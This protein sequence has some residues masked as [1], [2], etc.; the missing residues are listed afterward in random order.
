MLRMWICC[1]FILLSPFS[2][3][4]AA[5]NQWL[6][7]GSITNQHL[8]EISGIISA[9]TFEGYWVYNDSGDKARIYAI[10]QS[11][12]LLA[13]FSVENTPARDWEDMAAVSI[14]GQCYILCGDIGDNKG[15]RPFISLK[16]FP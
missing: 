8:G 16:L 3:I 2:L 12:N 6:N 5:E 15:K 11:G 14:R 7:K 1:F 10:D 4:Q 13:S 9:H